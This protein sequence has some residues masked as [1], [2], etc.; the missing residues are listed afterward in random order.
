MEVTILEGNFFCPANGGALS[1]ELGEVM[2]HIS[3]TVVVAMVRMINRFPKEQ[4]PLFWE[5]IRI[6]ADCGGL[7]G[8]S[9]E[10]NLLFCDIPKGQTTAKIITN[11]FDFL[12]CT[13]N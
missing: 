1:E 2:M 10:G 4:V 11:I 9:Q 13:Y 6:A 12:D 7:L 3:S 8:V 5:K